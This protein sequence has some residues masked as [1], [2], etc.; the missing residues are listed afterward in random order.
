MRIVL[1]DRCGGKI[2]KGETIGH[3]SAW[4]EDLKDLDRAKPEYN[5]WDFCPT[6]M[7]SINSYIKGIIC[8][9]ENEPAGSIA[10]DLEEELDAEPEEIEEG[11]DIESEDEPI[12]EPIAELAEE[13]KKDTRGGTRPGSGKK[14]NIDWPKFKACVDA[15]RDNKWLAVE[16]GVEVEKIP[17]WRWML[18]D[19]ISKG[20]IK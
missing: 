6:C 18:K 10:D 4:Y 15:G 8:M 14:P 11:P 3:L 9:P 17:K 1:C 20:Q 7:E 13:P 5:G 12:N 2:A 16:F 19:K